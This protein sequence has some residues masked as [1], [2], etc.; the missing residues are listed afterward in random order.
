MLA[1]RI[2]CA[3]DAIETAREIERFLEASDF[4]VSIAAGLASLADLDDSSRQHEVM[5]FAWSEMRASPYVRKWLDASSVGHIVEVRLGAHAPEIE[6]R[7]DP[8]DFTKWSRTRGEDCWKEL[9]RRLKRAANEPAP[10]I[11]PKRAFATMMA[12]AG[13]VCVGA[14]GVRVFDSAQTTTASAAQSEPTPFVDVV[15]HSE[16]GGI[17]P[18][19]ALLE[20]E[21][22]GDDI[23]ASRPFRMR[24]LP[25]GP[26]AAHSLADPFVAE[27]MEFRDSS[28]LGLRSP[29]GRGDRDG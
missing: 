29:F 2:V 24:P 5:L 23:V 27:P 8:I 22:A 10:R 26:S 20:P 15:D 16:R 21:D 4:V 1:I 19:A 25:S 17:S 7:E 6:R 3:W 14:V 28:F 12:V 18:A 13:A 11:E 9:E